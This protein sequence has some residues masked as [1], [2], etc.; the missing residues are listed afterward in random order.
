MIKRKQS[1]NKEEH[2]K[3]ETNETGIKN[4]T[5]KDLSKH[6]SKFYHK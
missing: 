5:K 6:I 1:D 4:R 3:R 2:N